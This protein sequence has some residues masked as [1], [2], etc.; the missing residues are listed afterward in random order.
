M[1]LL[2]H[3]IL[4]LVTLALQLFRKLQVQNPCLYQ[5]EQYLPFHGHKKPEFLLGLWDPKTY[6]LLFLDRLLSKK[7][8]RSC[9]H[10]IS[11]FS[12]KQ[13]RKSQPLSWRHLNPLLFA[14]STDKCFNFRFLYHGFKFLASALGPNLRKLHFATAPA[15]L[16]YFSNQVCQ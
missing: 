11:F 10:S 4:G 16:D 13:W 1:S 5:S 3:V 7:S 6:L 15:F 9:K 12:A 8:K 2:G 14:V